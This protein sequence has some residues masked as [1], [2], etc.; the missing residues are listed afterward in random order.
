MMKKTNMI[1]CT[2]I[3][4]VSSILSFIRDASKLTR[5]GPNEPAR[6]QTSQRMA[7]SCLPDKFNSVLGVILAGYSFEAYNQP[8]VGKSA[9]GLDATEVIYSSTSYIKSAFKGELQI[10]IDRGDFKSQNEDILERTLTGD[11]ID[12]FVVIIPMGK[13]TG[14]PQMGIPLV[15]RV[16][17][18]ARTSTQFNV[19]DPVW[20]ESYTLYI[21]D[22]LN[23][24]V[25]FLVFDKDYMKEDDF[26]GVGRFLVSDLIEETGKS[27]ISAVPIP[28][29]NDVADANFFFSL[30]LKKRKRKRTGTLLVDA[31]YI[32]LRPGPSTDA[33][34]Y[35]D[36]DAGGA[37]GSRL[38]SSAN[39]GSPPVKERSALNKAP[40]PSGASPEHCD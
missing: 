32:P 7:A 23:T 10:T 8:S 5:C 3:L 28:I 27:S 20:R 2:C 29:F 21:I 14:G 33:D 36:G 17:D 37:E 35:L 25:E 9:I 11:N 24:E 15:R 13:N 31:W 16:H 30:F 26:V 4:L 34:R 39:V 1:L 6:I 12:P 40:L 18:S 19:N 22:P 38:D